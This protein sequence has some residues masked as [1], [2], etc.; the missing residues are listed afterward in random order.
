M[1]TQPS[2]TLRILAVVVFNLLCYLVIGMEMAVVPLFV[3]LTL[4]Y[5][6]AIAG[7][8]VSLQYL[9]TLVTRTW[10]GNRIDTGGPKPVVI[11]GLITGGLS[12]FLL[13][14]AGYLAAMPALAL[15]LV[16]L[17]RVVLGFTES[18][19][20]VGAIMWNISRMGS[21]RTALVISWN[22]V[23]SYGGIALGAPVA[24]VLFSMHGP[25]AG[26]L[27]GLQGTGLLTALLLLGGVPFA[28][29]PAATRPAAQT[30]PRPSVLSVLRTVLPYGL[31]LGCGSVG[32]G[33][34]ASCLVLFYTSRNWGG[35]ALALAAF[36]GL[37]VM[38][39]FVFARYIDRLGGGV[40]AGIS[41]LLEAV[42]LIVTGLAPSPV[43]AG[44]GAGLTGAGFSLVFPAL[45]V[46]AVASAGEASRGAALGGYSIFL[47]LAI[48]LSGPLLGLMARLEGY[49]SLFF[50]SASFAV[51]GAI[52]S[53]WLHIGSG[54][55]D[56]A[57]APRS[58]G[59]RNPS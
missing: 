48:G 51:L 34:V 38:M 13:I 57:V 10:A 18:W 4:G 9:A 29:R 52:L 41:M 26:F 54:R 6:A 46:G 23:T 2:P 31:G 16:L 53:F 56:R 24:T 20:A 43:L 39:R 49:P 40:I 33:A 14:A 15:T 42:G 25:G 21:E 35:A 32:F 45:G 37:F 55:T 27:G 28:F 12:G 44:L 47:D 19:I 3:H 11:T 5:S 30:G 36:G 17:A 50:V 7:F 22:G 8:A 1:S 58:G 59:V